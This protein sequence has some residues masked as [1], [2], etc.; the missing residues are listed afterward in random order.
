MNATWTLTM[1]AAA[2]VTA[3]LAAGRG[4]G[5]GRERSSG[6][7]GSAFSGLGGVGVGSVPSSGG[8]MSAWVTPSLADGDQAGACGGSRCPPR[9][10]SADSAGCCSRTV[11]GN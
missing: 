2:V 10:A 1:G 4:P 11:I 6:T 3:V 7:T 8:G 5:V 9:G